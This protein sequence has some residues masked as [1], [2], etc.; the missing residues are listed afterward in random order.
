MVRNVLC[1]SFNEFL[2]SYSVGCDEVIPAIRHKMLK[3]H[4]QAVARIILY[5]IWMAYFPLKLSQTFMISCLFGEEHVTIKMLVVSFQNDLSSKERQCSEKI[6]KEY[7][8]GN[9]E[10]L[11]EVLSAYNCFKKPSKDSLFPILQELGHQELLQKPKYIANAFAEVFR[12]C[13]QLQ[14]PFPRPKE[15]SEFYKER[16]PT[17]LT[18][19]KA[20]KVNDLTDIQRS[21][22]HFL[23][24][25][26]KSLNQ[27]DLCRFLKFVTGGNIFP[28][29]PIQV[30]STENIIRAPRSR[31]CIPQLELQD[32]YNC[33]N[34]LA[35]EST[36]ILKSSHL[37]RFQLRSERGQFST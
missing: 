34:K 22:L 18:V 11:L 26:I 24:G 5:G 8:E 37:F 4:W 14:N 19:V 31:T 27:K 15:L 12:Y 17:S 32:T 7:K 10:D 23:Q 16:A 9:Q 28:D 29:H 3:E 2:T 35:E 25:F 20:L 33:Y 30:I 36:N 13:P 6:L 21:V 1:S